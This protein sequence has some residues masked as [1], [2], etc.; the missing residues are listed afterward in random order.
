M[1][2]VPSI[3]LDIQYAMDR[4]NTA[5]ALNHLQYLMCNADTFQ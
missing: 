1:Y 5:P 3:L 2:Y 4:E